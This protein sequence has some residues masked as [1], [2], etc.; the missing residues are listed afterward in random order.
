M[1][2]RRVLFSLVL[3]C[4]MAASGSVALAGQ[5]PMERVR[6]GMD[7]MITMLSDPVM[8][9]PA[10]HDAA[11]A[12]LRVAAERYIDFTLVTKYAVGRPW[13]D[14]S[15]DLRNQ[16][17]EAFMKLLERSYLKRI[18]A[19]G[20][21]NVA[22]ASEMI[23]GDKAKV[24]TEIIDKDKKIVVEFRLKIVQGQWMIYD[25]VAEGVSLVMNY[26]S[27]F[28]EILNKGNGE[29]LLKVI[30]DRIEQLDQA[31]EGEEEPVS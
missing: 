12:R 2:L 17:V 23:S 25:V 16:L 14:M 6:E 18:P 21:Q 7:Q 5:K 27:Q 19:Y 28:S 29:D 20:G 11:I 31:R 10:Q 30:R 24:L 8:Q 22:Y 4:L 3:V 1:I 9:D 26:R 15:D 13:L